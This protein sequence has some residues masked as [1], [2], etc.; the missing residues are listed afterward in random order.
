MELEEIFVKEDY[1]LDNEEFD[2]V[3]MIAGYQ[4]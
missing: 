1:N 2:M 3:P 4:G